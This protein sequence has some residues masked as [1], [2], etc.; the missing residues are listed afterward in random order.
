M[1]IIKV[2]LY[3]ERIIFLT[4]IGE[5]YQLFYK[6]SG[7]AGHGSRGKVLPH[8]LLKTSE[9]ETPDGIGGW[10]PAG[11]ITKAFIQDGFIR[12]YRSK[13]RDAFPLQMHPYLDIL[14][15]LDLDN[16]DIEMQDNPTE[17]NRYASAYITSIYDYV[18]WD[19]IN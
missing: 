18:D 16:Y 6:S 10:M 19:I 5:H 17:I 4:Q 13:E 9:G 3:H 11:W 8:L 7:L 14:E 15:N 12:E 2:W 1:T